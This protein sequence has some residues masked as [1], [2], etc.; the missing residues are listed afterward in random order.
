MT[1]ILTSIKV[2]SA[3]CRGL[4]TYEKRVDV[5]TYLKETNA[6]IVCLQD[7]HLRETDLLSVKQIWHE[8]YLHGCSNNSRGV[9]ILLHNNF[10]YEVPEINRDRVGNMLHLLISCSSVKINIINIYAPNQ[11]SPEFFNEIQKI[12]QNNK[13]DYN[14][15]CGDFNLVLD[16]NKDC[17]NYTSVNNPRARNKVIEMIDECNLVDAYR[18]FNPE[19]ILFSWRKRN[20]IKQ[21]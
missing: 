3:N 16:P 8:C 2:L 5:L 11:D 10:E 13:A 15:I 18:Y 6:S 1:D 20:P 14:I 4:R 9:S 17:K 19:S 12:T 21:A 7:T